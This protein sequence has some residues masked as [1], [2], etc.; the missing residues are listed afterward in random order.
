MHPCQESAISVK[1]V[2]LLLSLSK[3]SVYRRVRND[4]LFPKPFKLSGGKAS[5]FLLQSVLD[6]LANCAKPGTSDAPPAGEVGPDS[7]GDSPLPLSQ[8]KPG[9]ADPDFVIEA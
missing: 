5:R 2:C 9:D 6:Y 4:P 1:E 7:E 8:V 3:A